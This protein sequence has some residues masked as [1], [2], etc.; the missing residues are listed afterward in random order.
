MY[1][2]EQITLCWYVM[3]STSSLTFEKTQKKTCK[4]KSKKR[5]AGP[6]PPMQLDAKVVTLLVLLCF[7]A[8]AV[9]FRSALERE[10]SLGLIAA[11][12]PRLPRAPQPPSR[13][14]RSDVEPYFPADFA[15]PVNDTRSLQ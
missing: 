3:E 10:G 14:A 11:S 8:A 2:V 15:W 1:Y 9:L 7:V 12:R 6:P 4:N 13:M 5:A